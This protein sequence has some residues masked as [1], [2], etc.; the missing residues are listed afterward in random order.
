M[1]EKAI[2]WFNSLTDQ[3]KDRLQYEIP[4]P[5]N[6]KWWGDGLKIKLYKKVH[7]L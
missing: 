5:L 7:S 3:Q 2:E 4:T 1:K 6:Y